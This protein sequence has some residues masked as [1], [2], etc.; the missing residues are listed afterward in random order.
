M[1]QP[2][3][4][5]LCGAVAQLGAER[6]KG[7]TKIVLKRAVSVSSYYTLFEASCSDGR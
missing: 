5:S 3:G 2:K 7:T 6:D 1:K 4:V